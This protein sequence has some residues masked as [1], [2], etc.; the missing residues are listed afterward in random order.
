M[1]IADRLFGPE[2]DPVSAA[3]VFAQLLRRFRLDAMLTQER[4]AELANLS[5][6]AVKTL[7]AGRRR[8]PRPTTVDQLATALNL[9][10]DDRDRLRES[11]K[12]LKANPTAT[13][14]PQQLPPPIND[15]TGRSKHV[16]D[17]VDLLKNPDRSS[18]GIVISAIGG[19][20]GIGKTTLAIHAA[21]LVADAFADGQ[22]YLNLRGASADPLSSAQALDTLLQ[23]LGLAPAASADD[24]AFTAGRYRT[25]LA[26]R[27]LLLMLDDVANVEQILPLLPGTAG[28]AVLVTSRSPLTTLA[29]ARHLALDV[30]TEVEALELLAELVGAE[31]VANERAAA[32][33]VVRDCGLLPLA[34]RIAAGHA[35]TSP[36]KV[37]AVRL[38]GADGMSDIL[39]G[40]STEVRRSLSL[41]LDRLASSDRSDAAAAFPVLALFDGD[42]F[43]LRA[44]AAV[45]A[46]SLDDTEDLLEHL[47]DHSLLETPA[48]HRYRMHDLLQEVGRALAGT[49]LIEPERREIRFREL[50]CY[51]SQ[52]WRYHEL[53]GGPDMYESRTQEWSAAAVDLTDQVQLLEWIEAELPSLHRLIR[54]PTDD[55]TEQ[56]LAVRMALG[57]PAVAVRLMRFAE[58]R[59]ALSAIALLPVALPDQ[60]E[61]GRLYQTALMCGCLGLDDEG[62]GWLRRAIPVARRR[63]GPE[64]LARC[65]IDMGF[66]LGRLGRPAEGMPYAEEGMALV[67]RSAGSRFLSAAHLSIGVLAGQLGDLERQQKAFDEVLT[68][69]GATNSTLL[70]LPQGM[71]AVHKGMIAT[72]LRETGQHRKALLVVQD[73]LAD[74]RRLGLETIEADAL[75]ELGAVYL[76]MG[77]LPQGI[78][79]LEAGLRIASRYPAEHREAPLLKLLGE[80]LEATG[81]SDEARRLW[82]RAVLLY[83][84]EAD[85]RA[86]EVRRLLE[87]LV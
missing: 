36:L 39:T 3:P 29:G 40:P 78:E 86:A 4:L 5:S 9:S 7:E 54:R 52:L 82:Q 33:E 70:G 48:L 32:I 15:F 59:S 68:R 74:I 46:R 28:V 75:T 11:A 17:L 6:D 65:L 50:T 24:L 64:E 83:D 45:L 10:A 34:I 47:V 53:S 26:G 30:L 51:A 77:D 76:A 79:A 43:P 73:S 63:G 57:M 62:I 58:A 23:A 71:V 80:A 18:P 42:H 31:K 67:S 27:R 81:K 12:R 69:Y 22:L 19:M 37:L 14:V 55:T 35:G 20:G 21:H 61:I 41:S 38:A 72:S 85:S 56:L 49:W 44:A 16:A 66:G 1:L 13:G 87:E 84:R 2:D 8:Y 25:A 60:M